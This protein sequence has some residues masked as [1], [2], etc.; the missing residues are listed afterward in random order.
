MP[1]T[2]VLQCVE[3]HVATSSFEPGWRAYLTA[4][5]DEDEDERYPVEVVV[6]CPECSVREFGC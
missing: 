5:G 3:C 4:A 1:A 6:L 2:A